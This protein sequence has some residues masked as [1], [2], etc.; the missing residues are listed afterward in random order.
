MNA[1][2]AELERDG[3]RGEGVRVEHVAG[4]LDR[5]HRA[6]TRDGRGHALT[7]TLNLIVA[8]ASQDLDASVEGALERLGAHNPSRTLI[9]RRHDD[10]RLD[11]E[12]RIECELWDAAGRVGFCHDQVV[13]TGDDSR[14]GHAASL[15]APLLI[16]DL[17]TVLWLPD[18]EAGLPDP[19]LL[20]RT[21]QVLVDSAGDA[22]PL[23]SLASLV[24]GVRVHD[25]AWGRLEFWRA[26]TAAAFDPPERRDLLSRVTSLELRYEGQPLTPALLLA[27]WV[28]ARARWRPE[29]IEVRD[30]QAL[31]RAVRP[32]GGVVELSLGRD[33]RARGCGGV[34]TL[35]LR[36][37]SDEVTVTR[38]AATNRLRDLFAEA[39]MPLASFARGYA[40]ALGAATAMLDGGRSAA[41]S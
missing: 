15:L 30:G 5:L 22:V 1:S 3:W 34:E 37:D 8:P 26:A 36:A 19:L 32:D 11:A 2:H 16:P 13:L 29:R 6:H 38:G 20:E 40:E 14:L 10:D 25:L 27:G 21:Q 9:L 28:S 7:R 24:R 23:P 17:P 39:L 12:A 41:G 33:P 35:T 31:G 4:E 18:L